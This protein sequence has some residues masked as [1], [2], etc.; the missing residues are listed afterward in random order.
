MFIVCA[1]VSLEHSRLAIDVEVIK[2]Y[3]TDTLFLKHIIVIFLWICVCLHVP[4][5]E[6]RKEKNMFMFNCVNVVTATIDRI[7]QGLDATSVQTWTYQNGGIY[8][9]RHTLT[10]FSFY[11][12]S[13]FAP[14]IMYTPNAIG[15]K[16]NYYEIQVSTNTAAAHLIW[17]CFS[18][19]NLINK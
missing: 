13:C 1:P 19:F 16:L 3:L 9:C 5:I 14:F 10:E 15:G 12:K 18:F 17:L 7:K 2:I 6:E 8:K 11:R 4:L